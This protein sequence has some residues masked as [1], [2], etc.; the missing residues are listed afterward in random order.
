MGIACSAP[1]SGRDAPTAPPTPA[2]DNPTLIEHVAPKRDSTGPQPL[3]FEWTA[4]KGADEY[5]ISMY[6]DIDVLLWR[7]HVSGTSVDWPK[8]LTVPQGTYF[9]DVAATR[10]E[11]IIGRAGRA[12]FV[13]LDKK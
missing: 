4:V 13:I 12:A 7:Q 5:I 10:N 1:L 9:W 2:Q 11:Q 6:D 8:Q 3:R